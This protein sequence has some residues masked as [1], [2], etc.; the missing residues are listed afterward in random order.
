MKGR[1]EKGKLSEKTNVPFSGPCLSKI[2]SK[3][4]N[5]F[6]DLHCKGYKHY[7][8]CLFNEP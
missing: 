5:N 2:I 1:A 6:T 8:P 4:P 3:N 7:F